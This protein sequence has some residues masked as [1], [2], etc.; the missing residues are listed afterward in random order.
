MSRTSLICITFLILAL[1]CM[2][3]SSYSQSVRLSIKIDNPNL[4]DAMMEIKKQTEFDFLYN[5]DI[6]ALYVANTQID[7]E[8]GSIDEILNQLFANSRIDYRI[9]D[10]TIVFMPRV[11]ESAK[12]VQ[13]GITITGTVTDKDGEP[14]PGT[15]VMIKGTSQGTVTDANGA[16]SLPV[17]STNIS[18]IFSYIGYTTQELPVGSQRTINVTLREDA[19][20]LEEVVVVGYGHIKKEAVTG[21]VARANLEVYKDVPAN[22]IWDKLKG[23]VAGLNIGAI[24]RPGDTNSLLIR[25]QNSIGAGNTPLIVLDGTIFSGSI[26]DI[27]PNDIESFTVLKDASAAAVYGSRSANGVILIETKRGTGINGKPV[28][29]LD[30]NYGF[31]SQLKQLK[32]YEGDAYL[33]RVLDIRNLLG[34][35][36]D[37]SRIEFYLQE[38]ERKNYL[39]TPDHRPTFTNPYDICTQTAYNR[40]V[41]LS[42]ANRME[43]T[44]YYIAVTALEAK[45]VEINDQY[46]QLSA[47]VNIDSDITNWLN[48][49]VKTFYSYRDRSGTPPTNN[50]VYFSPWATLKDEDGNYLAYPQTTTSFQSPFWQMATD[51]V[52]KRN[53]L[54]GVVTATLIAPWVPGLTFTS[55]LANNLQWEMDYQFWDTNTSNGMGVNGTG[56]RSVWNAHQLMWDNMLKYN[57]TF[58]E[59]HFIDVTLLFSQEKYDEDRVTANASRFDNT[60]LGHYR[61]QSGTTQ[62]VSTSAAGDEAIGLMAR[63]TYTFN[64]KYSLTGT[65]RRDG[66]SAFSKN[67][68]FG[69]FPSVGVNWNISRETFMQNISFLDNL[70]LRASY[71]SN[72]NQSISRYQT[73]ARINSGNRYLFLGDGGQ[74]SVITQYISSLATNELGWETT[75][76]LNLGLDFGWLGNRINGS[77]D[78]YFT[79]TKDMIFWQNLPGMAG[80]SGINTNVGEVQN[81]GVEISLNTLNIDRS[82]FQWRSN[83]AFSLNRNKV[84]SIFGDKDENGV[85][86]DIIQSGIFMG[87]PIGVIYG[88][89]V[90]GMY[91][92]KDADN[93][94]IM[95]GW[96]PGEYILE[97]LDNSGTITGNN[98]RQ[99]LGNTKENFRWSFT[100]T[101]Q[102]KGFT[103]MFYINS[104]WGVNGWYLSNNNYPEAG[105][106]YWHRADINHPVYDYW[107]PTN[108]GAFFQRPDNGS[109]GAVRGY[110]PID[111]SFVKL[112]KISL[113]YD[114]GKWVK[115]W[116]INGLIVGVSADNIYTMAP[117]WIGLDPET[118][119][120]MTDL[121]VP[122]IRTL[123]FSIN[124]NF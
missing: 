34:Q 94:T 85:E 110:K 23:S 93:G 49:G 100:N 92:Q 1:N 82:G 15:A 97:D 90:L 121:A 40:N 114:V 67:K 99:I 47:R 69:T 101:F 29:N 42:V 106:G 81:R 25:G 103:L 124:V 75:T 64:N 50:K 122:S 35:E 19:R 79:S 116:K 39:A 120:G 80:I 21:A 59:K 33:Q 62:T 37:P 36:A 118:N 76:G 89:K 6:E 117:H 78:T 31:N 2:A 22:N 112:S 95:K 30:M 41:S 52:K 18:L 70:A 46:K 109:A 10:K 13:Q 54:N 102:Y 119:Q 26:M 8:D 108:T 27:S 20:E 74:S 105:G 71:G 115:Q 28:F 91:Q 55:T 65:V 12:T 53:R 88:Y 96:R 84:V 24:S 72:G 113:T 83:F 60:T 48:L 123:N 9:I 111:R 43:K 32:V 61:L 77:V 56:S 7:V 66:Y 73:L 3:I 104:I 44:R 5:K 38:E 86:P 58:H 16:Y 68:K 14:L 63:A 17:P 98:D 87:K 45:G 11:T 57:R 107:T 51:D 4:K